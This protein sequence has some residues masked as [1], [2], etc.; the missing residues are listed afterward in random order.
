MR[1]DGKRCRA[2]G[3]HEMRRAGRRRRG[4]GRKEANAPRVSRGWRR[5]EVGQKRVRLTVADDDGGDG[6]GKAGEERRRKRRR[7]ENRKAWTDRSLDG[8]MDGARGAQARGGH[9]FELRGGREQEDEK[10]RSKTAWSRTGPVRGRPPTGARARKNPMGAGGAGGSGEKRAHK[11]WARRQEGIEG[12][13]SRCRAQATGRQRDDGEQA[14]R[15]AAW[16][17]GA[18]ESAGEK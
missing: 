9:A 3:K 18:E 8:R 5:A 12:G 15:R 13:S 7:P 11:G 1:R 2:R 6:R 10:N 14:G 17:R 4:G 16:G